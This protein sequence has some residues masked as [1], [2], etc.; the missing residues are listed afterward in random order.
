MNRLRNT[1]G[2]R[3]FCIV[4]GGAFILCTPLWRYL[5]A[6]SFSWIPTNFHYQASLY[7]H[8]NFYDQT[9]GQFAGT[10]T[11]KA[12][13]YYDTVKSQ[14]PFISIKHVFDVKSLND[15]Q[16]IKLEKTYAVDRRNGQHVKGHGADKERG[17][18][19]FAPRGLTP[20]QGYTY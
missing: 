5:I 6:P 14:G 11:S 16:I 7:S 15:K 4:L 2:F 12:S 20:G 19:L 8:D 18:Y 1:S 17:G 10:Q 9:A 13:F 3:K